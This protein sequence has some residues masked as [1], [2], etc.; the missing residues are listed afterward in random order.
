MRRSVVRPRFF[1]NPLRGTLGDSDSRFSLPDNKSLGNVQSGSWVQL[2][3]EI[4]VR[5]AA[6]AAAAAASLWSIMVFES[7]RLGS[8]PG[9]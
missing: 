2:D 7:V 5:A 9:L 4:D 6:A 1:R 8:I 3:S